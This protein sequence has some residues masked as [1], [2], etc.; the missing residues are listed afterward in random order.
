MTATTPEIIAELQNGRFVILV[1]DQERENEGDLIIAAQFITPAAINFMETHGRG[2]VCYVAP[3]ARLRALGLEPLARQNPRPT[4]GTNF[5]A[6][7][8]AADGT[9]TGISAADRA[10]TV[11]KLLDPQASSNDFIKPGHLNTL[12]AQEGG[13]LRRAG[14]TEASADLCRLAGL[15]QAAVICEIKR[16]DGEMA[17]MSELESFA[18]KHK[19]VIGTIHDLIAWRWSQEKLVRLEVAT[20]I[21]NEFGDWEIR[22]YENTLTGEGHIAMIFGGLTK[23]RTAKD[24][25]VRVHSKCFT[26]DTLGSLRCD[27]RQQLHTAMQM[28][29]QEGA[30]VLVYLMQEGRGI[31]LK[32]KLKAY[33]LQDEGYDTVQAN[34][35]LGFKADLRE[36][37]IGAQILADIGVTRMRILT[38]NPKKLAGLGGFGLEVVGRVPMHSDQNEHNKSYLDTK[39]TKLGHLMDEILKH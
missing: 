24:V 6:L 26:G 30:G 32:N 18:A 39:A 5:F 36:Y 20:H 17:R 13:V 4:T 7:V 12:G 8:D 31:G 22:Y 29:A 15:A 27:C 25:L 34:E 21:P 3:E 28:I 14:H 10:R 37:G 33:K 1:D 23:L 16:E 35:K 9:T 38:N 11:H 2:M 19:L